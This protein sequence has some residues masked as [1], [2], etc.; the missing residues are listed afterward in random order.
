MTRDHVAV[1][2][3]ADNAEEV[4]GVKVEATEVLHG[5]FQL[6]DCPP[7]SHPRESWECRAVA[8]NFPPE[9]RDDFSKL[10]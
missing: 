10:F 4:D 9:S 5:S 6:P 2:K 7:D 1:F 8:F 3:Q